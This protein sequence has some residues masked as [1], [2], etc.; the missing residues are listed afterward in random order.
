MPKRLVLVRHCVNVRLRV[1]ANL[2]SAGFKL[3][4][5]WVNLDESDVQL[6]TV[7]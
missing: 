4:K 7:R 2:A 3:I 1:E 6:T 5:G